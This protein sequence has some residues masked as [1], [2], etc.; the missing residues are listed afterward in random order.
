MAVVAVASVLAPVPLV[1]V[2][3]GAGVGSAPHAA[4]NGI[5]RSASAE[6]ALARLISRLYLDIDFLLW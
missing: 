5:A 1:A 6:N 2:A 4:S 3:A